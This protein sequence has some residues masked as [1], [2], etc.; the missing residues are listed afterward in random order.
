MKAIILSIRIPSINL[1]KV[2]GSICSKLE[3]SNLLKT[4]NQ[5]PPCLYSVETI[6]L[7]KKFLI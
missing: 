5:N 2:E 4:Y 1:E 7:L 3:E 6:N